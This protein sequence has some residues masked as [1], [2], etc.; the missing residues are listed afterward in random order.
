MK[1]YITLFQLFSLVFFFN[2]NAQDFSW[3]NGSNAINQNGIYGTIGV[4]SA[5]NRPGGRSAAATWKDNSGNLWL[6]SG[7]GFGVTGSAGPLNDLW[8]YNPT[9]KQWTWIKGTNNNGFGSGHYGVYGT[10]GVPAATNMPGARTF[11]CTWTDNAGNLWLFGGNDQGATSPNNM[12]DLW[13]YNIATNQ[14]TWVNG[15]NSNSMF[16]DY[17]MQGWPSPTNKPGG[18][19]SAACWKDFG[20]NFWVF[21]GEGHATN[22][23][24]SLNDLWK[25]NL[26]TNEWTWVSGWSSVNAW[27]DYG[28]LGVPSSNTAPGARYRSTMWTDNSGNLWLFGGYGYGESSASGQVNLSDLWKFTIS[29]LEWTWKKGPKTDVVG[30]YGTKGTAAAANNPGARNSALGWKDATGN[31]WLFAGRG[32][33]ENYANAPLQDLWRYNMSTNQWVWMEGTKLQ[34]QNGI[35]GVIGVQHA[36]NIPGSREMHMGW[37]DPT[38]LWLFGGQGRP[39]TSTTNGLLNDLWKYHVCYAPPAPFNLTQPANLTVCDGTG[40]ELTASASGT[41]NWYAT[42]S[43]GVPLATGTVYTTPALTVTTSY[44]VQNNTCMASTARTAITVSVSACLGLKEMATAGKSFQIYPNPSHGIV[45]IFATEKM[46]L[47]IFNSLGQTLQVTEA[48]EKGKTFSLELPHGVYL[49][50]GQGEN[51]VVRKKL[52]VE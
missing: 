15:D 6:F 35:Y 49:I 33:N 44:Y 20:G 31:L 18:R 47:K 22:S 34:N 23:S 21:G 4:P 3:E 52:V 19:N 16:G 17:G 46:T 48:L 50:E 5:A 12:N 36:A 51:G 24:G 42:P 14:W 39:A 25:Y 7:Y 13:K 30:I 40:T 27:G 41:V 8:K 9:T 29:T 37:T 45:N 38:G 10:K 26:T 32:Y 11:A 1:F 2:I 28:T 43:G